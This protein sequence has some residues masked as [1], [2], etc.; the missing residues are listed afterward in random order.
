MFR[1]RADADITLGIYRRHP[2]LIR[3]D[4]PDGNPW[5]LSFAR[6][7]DMAN[8]SGLFHQ[9][10]DFADD[11]FNGWSYK[12]DGKEYVPLY[13]AKMLSHFDHR[14]STYRGAT[15]AQLNIGALPRRHRQATR[16]PRLEPL[17]RYWVER[18]EVA[19]KL[20]DRW[21]RGWL[22]GWRDI[23]RSRTDAHLYPFCAA[24]YRR[25]ATVSSWRSLRTAAT[26]L[27]CMPSGPA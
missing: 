19:A 14:F 11:E 4:D 17:A 18:T 7:F 26:G 22:L 12:R 13:E 15:Q 1:T 27:C 24:E 25:W 21:D 5:G 10:D 6:L 3:D 8:D 20:Q 2:V 9:P 23:T 16:R